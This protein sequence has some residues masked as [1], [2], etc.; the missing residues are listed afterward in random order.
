MNTKFSNKLKAAY[1]IRVQ[2]AIA[3]TTLFDTIEE[4]CEQYFFVVCP[5]VMSGLIGEGMSRII[6]IGSQIACVASQQDK[7]YQ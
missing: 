4:G 5:I 1:K 7:E 6:D 3:L 2:S